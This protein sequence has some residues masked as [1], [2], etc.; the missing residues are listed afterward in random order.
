MSDFSREKF[1][2]YWKGTE[3]YREY[4]PMLHTFGDMELPYYFAAEHPTMS[5]RTVLR[6]GVV[7]VHKP[8]LILPGKNGP[9]FGEGFEHGKAIPKDAMLMLRAI[10]LPYSKVSN[11]LMADEK[12]EYGEL[13]LVLDKLGKYLDEADDEYTGLIKGAVDG[14]DIS[15][16]RYSVG[17]IIKSGPGNATHYLEHLR[18]QRGGAIRGDERITDEDL[19]RLFG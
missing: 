18:R 15:L 4:E 6:K 8:H 7:F 3:V 12:L 14:M 16:M 9:E 17:L 10:G 11:R 5:D 19:R 1:E 13:S 2:E